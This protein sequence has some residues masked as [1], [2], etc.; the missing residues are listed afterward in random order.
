MQGSIVNQGV[1]LMLF[2]MGTVLVFLTLLVLAITLMSWVLQRY[3]PVLEITPAANRSKGTTTATA[4]TF[5]AG[6]ATLVAVIS[7]ALH[8]H[9][10]KQSDHT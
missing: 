4:T 10:S 7:A 2:G 8:Q 9:R 1:E 6:D 5:A 3:F